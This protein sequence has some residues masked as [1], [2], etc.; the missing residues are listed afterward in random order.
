MKD[1][2][3]LISVIAVS[4]AATNAVAES[5]LATD[6][7]FGYQAPA[8]SNTNVRTTVKSDRGEYSYDGVIVLSRHDT[9]N[10]DD[11]ANIEYEKAEFSAFEDFT[12]YNE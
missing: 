12:A 4:A 8:V 2:L 11:V 6:E 3:M 7:F 9:V 10:K 5:Y 1:L